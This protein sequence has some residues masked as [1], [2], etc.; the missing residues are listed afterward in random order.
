MDNKQI[1]NLKDHINSRHNNTKPLKTTVS[2]ES[3]EL[4][5]SPGSVESLGSTESLETLETIPDGTLLGDTFLVQSKVDPVYHADVYDVKPLEGSGLDMTVS[6]QARAFRLEGLPPMVK[7]RRYR[8]I[9]RLSGRSVLRIKWESLHVVVYKTN[10][11]GHAGDGTQA[12]EEPQ[13]PVGSSPSTTSGPPRK[14][15]K[16]TT[17]QGES[18]RARQQ[19][20]RQRNR[21]HRKQQDKGPEEEPKHSD[22]PPVQLEDDYG[23]TTLIEVD[24]DEFTVF[25]MLHLMTDDAGRQQLSEKGRLAFEEYLAAMDKEVDLG[26]EDALTDLIR[27]KEREIVFLCRQKSKFKPIVKNWTRYYEKVHLRQMRDMRWLLNGYT[28]NNIDAPFREQVVFQTRYKILKSGFEAL[29]DLISES[30][31]RVRLLQDKLASA[32]QAREERELKLVAKQEP[33]RLA[34][35]VKNYQK[36]IHEVIPGLPPYGDVVKELEAMEEQYRRVSG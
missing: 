8:C 24:A 27:I 22:I 25:Q 12:Q 3:F 11:P 26:D 21:Q 6:Y 30:E 19:S 7:A 20:R 10:G 16:K 2:L 9:K 14:P 15:R 31:N 18:D 28:A 5:E 32:R 4:V 34:K 17:R 23:P 35:K 29:P 1:L 36:W 33:K 13:V